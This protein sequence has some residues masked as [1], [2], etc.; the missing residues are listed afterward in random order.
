MKKNRIESNISLDTASGEITSFH[1][2]YGVGDTLDVI[3]IPGKVFNPA[4]DNGI[5]YVI[6]LTPRLLKLVK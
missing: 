2:M 3:G 6:V 5:E 4:W 1:T